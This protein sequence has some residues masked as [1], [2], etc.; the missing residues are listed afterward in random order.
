MLISL[1]HLTAASLGKKKE[2]KILA[3]IFFFF[4]IIRF[5]LQINREGGTSGSMALQV[6]GG[7]E[8]AANLLSLGPEDGPRVSAPCAWSC[9]ATL[10]F[11]TIRWWSVPSQASQATNFFRCCLW[12]FLS[13]GKPM[14]GCREICYFIFLKGEVSLRTWSSNKTYSVMF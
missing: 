10:L 6:S 4:T 13:P 7:L 11:L 14:N 9:A 8:A 3:K 12:L 5:K 2:K 1:I